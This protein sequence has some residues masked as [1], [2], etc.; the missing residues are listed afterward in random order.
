MNA[1]VEEVKHWQR[2]D[3][4]RAK[5]I[6]GFGL[7][8]VRKPDVGRRLDEGWEVVADPLMENKE[9]GMVDKAQHYR[10]LILMR[11]PKGMVDERNEFY[12][13]KHNKRVRA[14]A[15]GAAM[16]SLRK[17]ATQDGSE[18]E[19]GRPLASAIGGGLKLHQGVYTNEGL[20]HTDNVHIPV[21][22]HPDDFLED[23]KVMAEVQERKARS[24]DEP[25]GSPKQTK[26]KRR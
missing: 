8:Y 20:T 12:R 25:E 26:R 4:L 10:S 18:T 22:A 3:V 5:K 6:P 2:P 23:E 21:E 17:A 1:Q 14:T 7:K 16:S 19:D 15:R 24:G 9:G 11:M 13:E